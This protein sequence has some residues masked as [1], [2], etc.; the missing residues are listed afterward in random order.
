MLESQFLQN[1]GQVE[2]KN[3]VLLS[4]PKGTYVNLLDYLVE[5]NI[6]ESLFS[7]L[8]WLR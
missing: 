5:I 6:Y 1:P 7:G 3:I 2:I 4:S 8:P